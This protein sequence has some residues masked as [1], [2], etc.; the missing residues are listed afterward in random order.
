MK[1]FNCPSCDH[2]D[3][4]VEMVEIRECL[5]GKVDYDTDKSYI[6]VEY[7]TKESRTFFR[8]FHCHQELPR[9]VDTKE[10]FLAYVREYGTLML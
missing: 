2:V 4:L 5:V 10:K 1:R 7:P 3:E 8:C 9:H 6:M